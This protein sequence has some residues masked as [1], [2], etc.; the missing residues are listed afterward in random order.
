MKRQCRLHSG[1]KAINPPIKMKLG[2]CVEMEYDAALEFSGIRWFRVHKGMGCRGDREDWVAD[3]PGI[4]VSVH[5][6]QW[7]APF[8][9]LV[10]YESFRAAMIGEAK[11]ALESAAYRI[12]EKEKEVFTLRK[13]MES[14]ERFLDRS[15]VSKKKGRK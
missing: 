6:Y 1:S 5:N 4:C 14:L 12:A 3:V 8:W 10:R 13:G 7:R 15:N 9:G 2:R 11:S